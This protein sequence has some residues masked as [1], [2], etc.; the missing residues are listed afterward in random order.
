MHPLPLMLGG[1]FR[2]AVTRYRG[3]TAE[4]RFG[5]Q[6]RDLEGSGLKRRPRNVGPQCVSDP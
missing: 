2:G 3:L 1:N 5:E 6:G 4:R